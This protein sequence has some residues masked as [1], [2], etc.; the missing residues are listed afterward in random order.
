MN[1]NIDNYLRLNVTDMILVLISTVLICL[2]AK[3]FFWPQ[4]LGYFDRRQKL[5]ADEIASGQKAHA[6]GETFKQQYADQLKGAKNEAHEIIEAAK[7]SAKSEGA[8]ILSKARIDANNAVEKAQ[9]DIEREKMMAEKD[10]KKEITEV[11]FLA[12]EKIVGKELNDE[13]QKKYIDDFISN[14][15]E[16]PWQG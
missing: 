16:T 14:A 8:Q 11:A 3:H 12:A 10:I 1:I 13:E 6:E 2:L 5:I 15:G 7:Q 4:V 9:R